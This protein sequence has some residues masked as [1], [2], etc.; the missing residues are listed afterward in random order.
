MPGKR[1]PEFETDEEFIEF[2][3]KADTSKYEW[4]EAPEVKV[5][6]PKKKM[7]SFRLYPYIIEEIKKIA[8]E[9]NMSYSGIIQLWL[10]ER[11][12]KEQEIQAKLR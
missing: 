2:I 9:R 5:E 1:L 8:S 11:L 10:A 6:R 7:Y 12:A 3:E 4:E